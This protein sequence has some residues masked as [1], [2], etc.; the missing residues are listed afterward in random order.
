MGVYQHFNYY[1]EC[2]EKRDFYGTYF[3]LQRFLDH[4]PDYKL[5]I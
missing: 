5:R 3:G 1:D 2:D 4:N